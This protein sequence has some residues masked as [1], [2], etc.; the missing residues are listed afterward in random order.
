MKNLKNEELERVTGGEGEN[1]NHKYQIGDW[2]VCIGKDDICV[3]YI[4][5]IIKNRYHLIF[6]TRTTDGRGSRSYRGFIKEDKGTISC[7]TFDYDRH[8]RKIEK[9]EWITEDPSL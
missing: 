3:N 6:Y 8:Y 1:S 4:K 7:E 5:D 9:P 2:A